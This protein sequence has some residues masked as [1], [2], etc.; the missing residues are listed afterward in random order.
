MTEIS[1][2]VP[3]RNRARRLRALLES[4]AGQ[5]APAFETLVVDD[6]SDDDT[7]AVIADAGVRGILLPAPVGPAVAR[8]HGWRAAGG[9]LIVF[10]DDDLA[11]QPGWL[12]ALADAHVRDPEAIVQGRT[13]PDPREAHLLSAFS[14]SQQA[15]GP[16]PWFQTCNI[17]YPRRL[18]ERLGG[19]DESFSDTPG[20]DTD[21]GCR[22]VEQ[23]TRVIYEPR[24]LNWHAVH[25]PGALALIRSTQ[26]WRGTVRNVARHPQLRDAL[27]RRVF[28]K[29][30]H[31]RLLIAA[32]GLVLARTAPALAL[33]AA[34]PYLALHRA[35]H[36]SYVGTAAALPAHLAL[37][38][39]EV[40]AMLRGSVAAGTLVL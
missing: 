5:E 7:Q 30:S 37:D 10:T 24:A 9:E 23:G 33:A 6:A 16:G 35:E 29:R 36:G 34:V 31:E 20:E 32:A 3:T 13:T 28:W 12:Q 4:L 27:H 21:L 25:E 1:I 2:V 19:F 8:N 39:A 38:A 40:V 17:A 15:S 11:A 18:L 14:R 22:A 26:K